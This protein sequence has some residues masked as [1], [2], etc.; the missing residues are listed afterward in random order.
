M[1]K[2]DITAMHY[3]AESCDYFLCFHVLEHVPDDIAAIREIF[4]VLRP[5]GQGSAAGLCP[6]IIHWM[7][8]WNMDIP[9]LRDRPRS[10]IFASRFFG[11][12][13]GPRIRCLRAKCWGLFLGR[14]NQSLRL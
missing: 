14:R 2:G 6:L 5:G 7:K 4:R 11:Q 9:I 8:L 10:A 1:E 12:V 3:A 13:D